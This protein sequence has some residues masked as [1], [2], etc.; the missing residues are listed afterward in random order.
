[1]GWETPLMRLH[2]QI[3]APQVGRTNHRNLPAPSNVTK[4]NLHENSGLRVLNVGF[5]MGIIDQLLQFGMILNFL[6]SS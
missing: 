5:G 6:L 3:M 1:M 4:G 2:A